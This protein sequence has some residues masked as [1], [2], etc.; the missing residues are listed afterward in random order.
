[1]AQ[2]LRGPL[3]RHAR[4]MLLSGRSIGRGLFR[5][6]GLEDLFSEHESG[7]ENRSYHL[8]ALLMLEYW[9]QAY[10]DTSV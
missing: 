10:I 7:H 8:W 2:W 5:K 6:E 1:M 9:Y 4:E 3:K